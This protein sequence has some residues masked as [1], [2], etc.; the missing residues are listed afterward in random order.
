MSNEERYDDEF[1]AAFSQAAASTSPDADEVPQDE[2][3]DEQPGEQEAQQEPT[4]AAGTQPDDPL[5][6]IEQLKRERDDYKHRF[7]S[8]AGRIAAYQRQL[9]DYQQQIQQVQ[10]SSGSK[11][12]ARE[13]LAQEFNDSSWDELKEDFPE[14]AHAL[15]SRLKK[16]EDIESRL[17]GFEKK[18]QPLEQNLSEQT[19][20]REYAAL[21][22]AHPDWRDI[23]QSVEFADWVNTQPTP[24]RSLI[25]S[26]NAADAAYLLNTYKALNGQLNTEPSHG[27]SVQAERNQKLRQSMSV[28]ARRAQR[29]DIPDDDFEAAFNSFARARGSSR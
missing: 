6:L 25:Q 29:R 2:L 12:E 17:S 4:S 14:I 21:E 27:S 11:K 28:P 22:A 16:L 8:N 7:D 20:S 24:V 23:A 5:A 26:K 19:L 9:D 1:A 3:P 18:I 15:D 13:T 10:Q